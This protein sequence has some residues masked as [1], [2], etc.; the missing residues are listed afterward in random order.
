MRSKGGARVQSTQAMNEFRPPSE[1]VESDPRI[2]Q[3][4]RV[5]GTGSGEVDRVEYTV[6]RSQYRACSHSVR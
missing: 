5:G 2:N 3:G 6:A 1:L 4:R